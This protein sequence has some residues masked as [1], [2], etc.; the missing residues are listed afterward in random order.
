MF[1]R[2]TAPGSENRSAAS[3]IASASRS[4]VIMSLTCSAVSGH[5][6]SATGA[7][8]ASRACIRAMMSKREVVS[9]T[10]T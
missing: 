2:E 8:V 3:A 10:V 9:C 7:M 5:T 4:L 6:E 1:S